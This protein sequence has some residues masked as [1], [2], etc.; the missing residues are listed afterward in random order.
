[1]RLIYILLLASIQS[2]SA[3]SQLEVLGNSS[4]TD[5]RASIRTSRTFYTQDEV[6]LQV[7]SRYASVKGAVDFKGIGGIIDGGST[8]LLVY[9][10]H[11]GVMTHATNGYALKATS[12]EGTAGYFQ[13]GTDKYD[14]TLG[15]STYLSHT[16]AH[17]IGLETGNSL[18]DLWLFTNNDINLFLDEDGGNLNAKF[19]IMK[20]DGD[21]IFS[22]EESGKITFKDGSEIKSAY[23]TV[24]NS[25]SQGGS[26]VSI[27]NNNVRT[28]I[29]TEASFFKNHTETTIEPYITTTAEGT[30]NGGAGFIQ[31]QIF[32]DG[33]VGELKTIGQKGGSGS[34]V[35]HL[36][37]VFTNLG[38]ATQNP[39][40][41]LVVSRASIRGKSSGRTSYIH[42]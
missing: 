30:N 15:S 42:T 21:E 9:G 10:Y 40:V 12:E 6:G 17:T 20:S 4:S 36:R 31:Y 25:V 34:E 27:P 1:M 7:V 28:P 32:I 24:Y 18:G 19:S 2:V 11:D 29:G 16:N 23:K 35:V 41:H 22:V 8:G 14:I 5:P 33:N 3:Q 39:G 38:A 13:G 37:S 26:S